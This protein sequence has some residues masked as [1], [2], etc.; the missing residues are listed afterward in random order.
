MFT[1]LCDMEGP[2]LY[3]QKSSK[4]ASKNAVICYKIYIY[5]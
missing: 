2:D 4:Y 3:A 5:F 1:Q